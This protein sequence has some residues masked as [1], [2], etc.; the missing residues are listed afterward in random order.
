[1][2]LLM[3]FFGQM[4]GNGLGYF[5]LSIYQALGFDKQMQFNMNLI[6]TCISAVVAWFAVSLEDRMPRRK[7]LVWGTLG[8]SLMLAANAILSAKWASYGDGPKNLAVGRLGVTFY[9]LFGCVYAFTYTPLQS[10]YPAECLETTI[11][12]K[13]VAMK[14]FIISCTSFINLFC[15]PIAYGRIGWKYVLVF[16]GWDAFEAVIWYFFGV[17][18]QGRTLEELDEI[19]SSPDPVKASKMKK[20][21][22]VDQEGT[23]VVVSEK[24]GSDFA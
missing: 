12:A 3:G 17:E 22:V 7:V 23:V 19:F 2:V 6:G 14:I 4:S 16:V 21:V 13:G 20:Q 24:A 15:T 18:T 11:R 1:M 5:S 9:L 10:L 8:C